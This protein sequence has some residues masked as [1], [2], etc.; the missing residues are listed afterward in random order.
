MHTWTFFR[1]GG[2]DQVRLSSGA[3]LLALEQLD[4]K[5]WLALSCPTTGLEFDERTLQAIDRDEDG[6]IRPPELIEA[7]KR[8][9]AALKNPDD[10]LK[11][12]SELPLTALDPDKPEGARLLASAKTILANLGKADAEVITVEDTADT[13]RI[14][15]QARFNGDGVIPPSAAGDDAELATIIEQILEHAGSVPDRSG[16]AGIDQDLLDRFFADCGAF[17]DWWSHSETD[18]TILPFGQD[19]PAAFAAFDAVRAK[20]DDWFTR[21]RLAAFD[22]RATGPMNRDEADYYDLSGKVLVMADGDLAGF[23]LA[24][25]AAGVALPLGT[26]LNPAWA[27]PM[28]AF[29]DQVVRPLLGEITELSE[30]GWTE[31]KS[32]LA[33]FERWSAT[34]AG[35]SV[36]PLGIARVREL[37]AGDAK[38]RLGSL[39]AQDAALAPE[40]AAIEAVDELVRFHR[41]LVTL[42]RNY[43]SFEQFYGRQKAVFQCGTLYLDQRAVEL[44]IRVDDVGKH[45]T[46]AAASLAYV[47][48][49]EC[50]RKA[51]GEKM[52]IAAVITGGDTDNLMVGRN[53]VFYDRKGRDWDATIVRIV[54]NPIA[55]RQ[56][57]WAPYKKFFRFVE[58]QIAAF[59]ASKD[60]EVDQKASAV[61]SGMLDTA[62]A[63]RPTFDIAKF[64]G[65]FAAIGLALGTLGGAV[66]TLLAAFAQL[67]WWQMPLALFGLMLVISG[68]SVL[69][70]SLKLRRRNLGPLLDASGWAINANARINIP[71]GE[72]LTPIAR[73]P[74]G[75]QRSWQD[76]YAEPKTARQLAMAALVLVAL[77]AGV[78]Y[79]GMATQALQAM[80]PPTDTPTAADALVPEEAETP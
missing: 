1:A 38:E 80:S 9:A 72:A 63:E 55:V 68:P 6:R 40:A 76:P 19:T 24:R 36:Q 35:A 32:R 30:E 27:A 70:A 39:I 59:A 33:A 57:F 26:G 45:A 78:W 17:A 69:L 28:A 37:L 64:A 21:C 66:A 3:D 5:L 34:A 18:E 10:L 50:V 46:L 12:S 77:G 56:A 71:F 43:V 11:G 16:A 31:L 67:A 22:P 7:V 74:S 62:A 25:V 54:E 53:G 52:N 14:F 8:A 48:Y 75:S 29:R 49:C 61:A 42:L 20:I 23:P 60:Q 51:T 65:I 2:F 79:S 73:L 41:D 47:A 13:A 58:D 4:Q 44:C 15:A